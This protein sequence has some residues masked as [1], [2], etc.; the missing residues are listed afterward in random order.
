[1][2]VPG[3]DSVVSRKVLFGASGTYS[4]VISSKDFFVVSGMVSAV[5]SLMYSVAISSAYLFVGGAPIKWAKKKIIYNCLKMIKS[6]IMLC[7]I[8]ISYSTFT[9]YNN[10]CM[11]IIVI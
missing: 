2:D 8:I 7:Y 3:I 9:I 4:V 5:A 1:M 6:Y 10:K 11:Y